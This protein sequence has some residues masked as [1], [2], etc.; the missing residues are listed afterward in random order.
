MDHEDQVFRDDQI[1]LDGNRYIRCTFERCVMVFS[2]VSPV[3]L[4][5]CSFIE[6]TW[7]FDG[8]AALT[9]NFMKG[10]YHGAGEG[11]REL[12]ERT[13]SDIRRGT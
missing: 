9:V 6:T 11:G 5:G 7:T 10:L 2:G 8:A 12:V 4:E 1:H 3:A 13:F